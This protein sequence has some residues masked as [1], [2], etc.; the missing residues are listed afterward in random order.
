MKWLD[1]LKDARVRQEITVD[2]AFVDKVPDGTMN[3]FLTTWNAFQMDRL[4]E[5]AKRAEWA[6]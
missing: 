4:I 1:E 5:I 6:Y 3:Y 2:D